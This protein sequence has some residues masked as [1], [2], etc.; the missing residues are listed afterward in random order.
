MAKKAATK[1]S[2]EKKIPVSAVKSSQERYVDGHYDVEH[3]QP[4]ESAFSDLSQR[5]VRIQHDLLMPA[6]TFQRENVQNTI[7]VFGAARLRSPEA[8]QKNLDALMKRV[9]NGKPSKDLQ[10]KITVAKRSL[11]M[12]KYY[13]DC[14]ELCRRMQE[15]INIKNFPKGEKFYITTGGGPGIMEAANKGAFKAGGRTVGLS[16]TIPDEQRLNDYVSPEL[17][18]VFHYFLMRKFW[19]LFFA[20]AIIIFPGGTGTFDEFFEVFTLMKTRKTREYIPLV[21]YGREF[22]ENAVNFKKLIESDVI[23]EGDLNFF[24]YADTVEEA[25]S[26]ITSEIERKHLN[27]NK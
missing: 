25:F 12:S 1:K 22:W 20:K 17:A 5:L 4:I 13:A 26:Y 14:E 8:A 6:I 11:K 27:K 19:L 16:I 7:T 24:R 9:K 15:W 18:M 2:K 10:E 23:T 21:L 3:D